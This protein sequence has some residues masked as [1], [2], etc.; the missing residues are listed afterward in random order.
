MLVSEGHKKEWVVRLRCLGCDA[1]KW[2]CIDPDEASVNLVMNELHRN[3]SL[4]CQYCYPMRTLWILE[5][6]EWRYLE[7]EKAEE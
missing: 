5:G 3:T 2:I 1:E 7:D 4:G 6:V